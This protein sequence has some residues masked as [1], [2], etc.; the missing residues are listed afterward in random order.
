MSSILRN[1]QFLTAAALALASVSG[2]AHAQSAPLPAYV[3]DLQAFEVRELSGNYAP[4]DGDISIRDVTPSEW[5][6]NDP[7]NVGLESVITAWSGGAKGIG[8]RLFVHGGGH[9]DSAN[10]GLYIFDF[11]GTNRPAG[12]EDNLEIS[13]VSSVRAN[14]QTYSDGRPV[15]VHT[16]D[17]AVYAHHNN[18]IYRFGGSQ[19]QNGFMSDGSFKYNLSS[20]TWS[21]LPNYPA[22]AGGAKTIYDP[23]SGN[24]FV[25]MNDADEGFFYRTS[26]DTWSGA[27]TY[28]GGGLPYN[29]TAAWDTSRQRGIIV[30]S[31]ERSLVTINFSSETVNMSRMSISGQTGILNQEGTSVV[32]DPQRD[33]YWMFGGQDSSAGWRNLYEMNADGPPW[34]ITAHPL[35]GDSIARDNGMTGSWGRFVLMDD[36]RAIGVIASIDSPAYIVR[37]PDGDVVVSRPEP[38]SSLAT[39]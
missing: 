27:R 19:Y 13:S 10:N 3:S 38:P 35:G 11:A 28:S 15:S 8:S 20:G 9:N 25:T 1:P 6:N 34:Q 32:Y 12:W 33:V 37:L 24:I 23:A 30:G 21:Q 29:V 22:Q 2:T 26:N 17:G 36:W 5:I 16:Y 31:G 4:A 14:R 39:Q 7:S 18:H